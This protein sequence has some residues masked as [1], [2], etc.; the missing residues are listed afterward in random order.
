MDLIPSSFQE[1]DERLN[2]LES[3]E[4]E[5][6]SFTLAALIYLASRS[7]SLLNPDKSQ[8]E[9]FSLFFRFSSCVDPKLNPKRTLKNY[10]GKFLN[11][12]LSKV[13]GERRI[14]CISEKSLKRLT[15]VLMRGLSSSEAERVMLGMMGV[16]DASYIYV[17]FSFEE[18]LNSLFEGARSGF[19]CKGVDG[20]GV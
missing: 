5:D 9:K 20:D 4:P 6:I 13:R 1:L 17:F 18:P 16:R 14:P 8:T 7:A 3:L 2:S 10:S 12:A 11:Y 19:D 15:Q